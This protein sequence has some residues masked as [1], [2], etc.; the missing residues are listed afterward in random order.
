MTK[1]KLAKWLVAHGYTLDKYGHYQKANSLF[2][3]RFKMQANSAR[4][5]TKRQ[6]GD[7]NEWVRV[8]SGYYK[9]LSIAENGKLSGMNR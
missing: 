9:D 5:E 8:S 1:D 6:I 7:H 4:Y 3:Y 2:T